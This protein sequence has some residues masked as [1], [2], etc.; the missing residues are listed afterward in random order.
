MAFTSL[1]K[2]LL[3][4]RLKMVRDKQNTCLLA[5]FGHLEYFPCS[6][7]LMVASSFVDAVALSDP[8]ILYS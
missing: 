4:Y 6:F 7:C 8:D 2:F 5:H 1:G 3:S